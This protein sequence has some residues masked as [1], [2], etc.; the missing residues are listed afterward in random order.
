MCCFCAKRNKQPGFVLS[1]ALN[2]IFEHE[3]FPNIR[4]LKPLL[5]VGSGVKYQGALVSERKRESWGE[6]RH[7]GTFT[8]V[9]Q[10]SLPGPVAE[11][12]FYCGPHRRGDRGDNLISPAWALSCKLSDS[13]H[14]LHLCPVCACLCVC[15]LGYLCNGQR[16]SAASHPQGLWEKLNQHMG[17]SSCCFFWIIII[18]VVHECE[19]LHVFI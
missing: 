5:L 14:K 10:I 8:T 7:S 2:V 4:A 19:C 17:L 6:R 9:L 13:C 16:V 18:C 3:A 15:F 1:A 12:W 11:V